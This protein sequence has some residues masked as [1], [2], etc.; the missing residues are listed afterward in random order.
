[1]GDDEGHN[2]WVHSSSGPRE[3]SDQQFLGTNC[4]FTHTTVQTSTDF[5][6]LVLS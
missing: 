3:G 5:Q 4:M 2:E 6:Y 1:M